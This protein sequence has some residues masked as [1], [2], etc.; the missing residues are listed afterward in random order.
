MNRTIFGL[1]LILLGGLQAANKTAAAR[2]QLNN[3]TLTIA[4]KNYARV[5]GLTLD[6]AETTATL[7]FRKAGVRAQWIDLTSTPAGQVSVNGAGSIFEVQVHIIGGE[8]AERLDYS[9]NVMGMAPGSDRERQLVY[10]FY[11]RVE[12]LAERQKM[13]R[14]EGRVTRYASKSQILGDLMAHELG[15]VLLNLRSH[16]ATG[17]MRGG[18]NLKD[19]EDVGGGCLLFTRPQADI[20]RAEVASRRVQ[21]EPVEV[22]E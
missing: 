22:A 17:I 4:V 12:A 7:I 20:I 3:P 2:I 1:I 5:D 16:S 21:R 11:D 19:L 10:V 13:A 14:V 15:H 6:E 18:W 9:N 8:M